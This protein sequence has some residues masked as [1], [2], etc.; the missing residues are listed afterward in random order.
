MRSAIAS[1]SSCAGAIRRRSGPDM[2]ASL[3][4]PSQT[5]GP[6]FHFALDRPE[7]SDLTRSGA[8]GEKIVV[9]GQVLD[10]DGASCDDAIVEIWQANA[11][12]RYAHP[13]DTPADEHDD[14]NFTGFG[15]ALTDAGGR[16]RFT[17]KACE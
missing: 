11:A 8:R 14:P 13:E 2:A 5:V 10:G 12:G 15:R 6:F 17:T 4:T 16:Y 3:A 1:T 9:E 7:W